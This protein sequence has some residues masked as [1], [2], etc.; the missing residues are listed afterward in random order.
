MRKTHYII[1]GWFTWGGRLTTLRSLLNELAGLTIQT[2]VKQASSFNR[3]L[4]VWKNQLLPIEHK[5]VRSR[6]TYNKKDR[7][8]T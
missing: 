5:K 4:R 8:W 1:A 2:I 6:T 7:I 3:D